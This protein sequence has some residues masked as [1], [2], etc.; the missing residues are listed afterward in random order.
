MAIAERDRI[1]RDR[2][3]ASAPRPQTD[4]F[5]AG[6]LLLAV[7]VAAAVRFSRLTDESYWLDEVFS[8]YMAR[9]GNQEMMAVSS[10]EPH[11]VLYYLVLR[12]WAGVFGS[13]DWAL[14]AYSAFCGTLSVAAIGLVGWRLFGRRLGV[15]AAWLACVMP[16]MVHYGQ[17]ARMYAMLVLL[18]T[19][20]IGGALRWLQNGSA[21][22]GWLY[23]LTIA[24]AF[25][26]HYYAVYIWAILAF[27][28][29]IDCVRRRDWRGLGQW[30]LWNSVPLVIVAPWIPFLLTQWH[31]QGSSHW[32]LRETP[33]GLWALPRFLA[34][35]FG[36]PEDYGPAWNWTAIPVLIA[37]IAAASLLLRRTPG[38]DTGDGHS[39]VRP[40]GP[41]RDGMFAAP[42]SQS[43]RRPFP[44]NER[45]HAFGHMR[46]LA[47]RPAAG[48]YASADSGTI[49]IRSGIMLTLLALAPIAML[50]LLSQHKNMWLS[51][52]LQICLPAIAL[53]AAGLL[54]SLN[55]RFPR[56]A[57][58][59]TGLMLG[60]AG[61]T[62][63]AAL[64]HYRDERWSSAAKTLMART[65]P[66]D[67]I[68][69]VPG[70]TESCLNRYGLGGD[71]LLSFDKEL[72]DPYVRD[73]IETKCRR[74]NHTWLVVSQV[75]PD[76]RAAIVANIESLAGLQ[77]AERISEGSVTLL[78]FDKVALAPN[79]AAT[80]LLS[81]RAQDLPAWTLE[82]PDQS[83]ATKTADGDSLRVDVRQAGDQDWRVQ[84]YRAH[85]PL[86]DGQSYVLRFTAR[87]ARPA[88]VPVYAG[89]ND[90]D[91]H[92]VGLDR[93][94]RITPEEQ[95]FAM[96]FT[97][98]SLGAHPSR[99]PCFRLGS[100]VNTYWFGRLSLA[101]L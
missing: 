5:F 77:E 68:L 18:I 7:I 27:G 33:P 31:N 88:D 96:R 23:G 46:Q 64:G 48:G 9:L 63:V 53:G 76:E 14:R 10:N 6:A 94:V 36:L 19:L 39:S 8:G 83:T 66:A 101:T 84:L 59:V 56:V 43:Q 50:W 16:P 13:G 73:T 79:H 34:E 47:L 44:W 32:L 38:A 24:A 85:I 86:R 95:T 2:R 82:T 55:R 30:G 20:S 62:S 37:G 93:T 3:P 4:A 91:Y 1:D 11:P 71:R 26:S 58:I 61:Y 89:I 49:D 42:R 78:R 12:A 22:G 25:Y 17:E 51:R 54:L 99:I 90:G 81:T 29:G 92:Y 69:V 75:K 41:N 87:A 15:L 100:S 35:C 67:T 28:I 97:V 45:R 52:Y 72:A 98:Q 70:Y 74:S 65:T 21:V 60:T 57:V 40:F 80:N